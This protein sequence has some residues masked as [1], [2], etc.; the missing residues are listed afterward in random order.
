MSDERPITVVY[1]RLLQCEQRLFQ[2]KGFLS[3]LN[4]AIA[5][6]EVRGLP[7]GD[8]RGYSDVIEHVQ[9]LLS[10]VSQDVEAMQGTLYRHDRSAVDLIE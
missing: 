9:G 4:K 2:A 3:V 1:N 6:D 10:Q 5:L 8:E 7:D